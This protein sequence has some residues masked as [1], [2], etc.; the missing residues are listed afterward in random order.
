LELF[1]L[2]KDGTE[3]PIE[4]SL[5]PLETEE[6]LI[7]SSA[8]RDI[9][10][11][12]RAEERFRGLLEAAPD[13]VVIVNR[14]GKILR[15]ASTGYGNAIAIGTA[16]QIHDSCVND[17]RQIGFIPLPRAGIGFHYDAKS[18]PLAIGEVNPNAYA[19]GIREGD[20]LLE[21]DSKPIRAPFSLL[22]VLNTKNPGDRVP[23]KVQRDGSVLPLTIEL[24]RRQDIMN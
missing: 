1:G 6:G 15:C 11:R 2:R 12:K 3:F 13:A 23:L 20:L 22:Q 9:T 8:I 18:K 24:I 14:E 4:I 19:A 5:S 10:D 16:Q 7:V 17:A 21:V